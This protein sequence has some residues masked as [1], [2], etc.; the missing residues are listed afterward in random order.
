MSDL[1]KT[2]MEEI[3]KMEMTMKLSGI[4][5]E[6]FLLHAK[7]HPNTWGNWRRGEGNPTFRKFETAKLTLNELLEED[8]TC[9]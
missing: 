7:L 3:L 5:K 6:A 1:S 2:L 8:T 9:D 4:S